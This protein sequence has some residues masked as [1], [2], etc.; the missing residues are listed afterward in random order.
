MPYGAKLLTVQTQNGHPVLWA[1]VDTSHQEENR[2]IEM[3]GTGHPML[4]ADPD[5]YL[6]TFQY[7]ANKLVF[8][9]F[10]SL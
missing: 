1:L 7:L 2:T 6:G 8:H 3:R 9:V 5:K 10:E 4:N